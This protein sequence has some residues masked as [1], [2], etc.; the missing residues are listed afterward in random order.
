[1][2]TRFLITTSFTLTESEPSSEPLQNV[3]C[4]VNILSISNQKSSSNANNF[5]LSKINPLLCTQL[6]L[7][8]GA[9]ISSNG[10]LA[11]SIT[12]AVW[13]EIESL[14]SRNPSLRVILTIG[15]WDAGTK[16]FQE[17]GRDG[18]KMEIFLNSVFSELR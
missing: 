11:V 10:S 8:N 15:G 5:V 3:I 16:G 1:M 4:A 17:V 6:M 12:D 9:A 14:K 2:I 7:V 18:K 13:K